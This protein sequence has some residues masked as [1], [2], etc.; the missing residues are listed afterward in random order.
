MS[1]RSSGVRALARHARG[2]WFKSRR[3]HPISLVHNIPMKPEIIYETEELVVLNKPSGMLVHPTPAILKQ[4]KKDREETL[5]DWVLQKYPSVKG[6]G[7]SDERPGIVHRLDRDTSGL[8]VVALNEKAYKRLKTLFK[9]RKVTKKYYALVWGLP[10]KDKGKI[11][12]EITALHGKRR[13][14][15]KYSQKEIGKTRNAITYWA[16]KE[17]YEDFSLLSVRPVTGRNHQ[18][19]VH[20][21]SIGHPLVC[22]PLYGKKKKCP[23]ALGRLFLHAYFLQ[24]PYEEGTVLEFEVG[25]PEELQNFLEALE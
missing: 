12:K 19:R 8:M 22:D 17:K 16:I 6:V 21:D 24:I 11:E 1:A 10:P 2:P 3:A 9:D 25:L 13:T 23:E 7:E 14:V 18:I 5:A 4:P 15:E 20:M